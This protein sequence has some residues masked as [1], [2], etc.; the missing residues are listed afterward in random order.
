[1]FVHQDGALI[2]IVQEKIFTEL[3]I[4]KFVHTHIFNA[5]LVITKNIEFRN[6]GASQISELFA[7]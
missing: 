2:R 5:N 4:F 7:Q 6:R 1:M 3:F